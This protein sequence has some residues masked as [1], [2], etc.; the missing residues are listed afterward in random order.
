VSA[1]VRGLANLNILIDNERQVWLYSTGAGPT[2]V[3][4]HTILM[5]FGTGAWVASA[6]DENGLG[7]LVSLCCT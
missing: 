4:K 5:G 2:I 6:P 7:L 1:T 3:P